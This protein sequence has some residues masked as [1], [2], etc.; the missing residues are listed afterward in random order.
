VKVS[1]RTIGMNIR[2]ARKALNLSQDQAAQMLDISTIHY[3]RL[4]RGQRAISL[5]QLAKISELLH[6][7]FFSLLQDAIYDDHYAGTHISPVSSNTSK[8]ISE[9]IDVV[10][11][12]RQA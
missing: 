7:S 2:R 1:H 9:L 4:E 6:V 5:E 10:L 3:G 12:H 8:L 11:K